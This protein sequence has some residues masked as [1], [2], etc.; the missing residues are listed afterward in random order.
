MIIRNGIVR[1][2]FDTAG[3]AEVVDDG[4]TIWLFHGSRYYGGSPHRA[5]EVGD[6]VRLRIEGPGTLS[7]RR[8][9][10]QRQLILPLY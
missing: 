8:A 7:V 3:F 4:G 1:R 6:L 9:A 10:D 2:G 5:P